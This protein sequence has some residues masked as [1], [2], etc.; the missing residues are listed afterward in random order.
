MV[1]G[2]IFK[3]TFNDIHN[4]E[5]VLLNKHYN[6]KNLFRKYKQINRFKS[7]NDTYCF[8]FCLH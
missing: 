4:S 8:C 3:I 7:K 5:H 2:M 6:K 1:N